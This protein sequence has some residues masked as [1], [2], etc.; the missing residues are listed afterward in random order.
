[1]KS[2]FYALL[3]LCFVQPVFA[4]QHNDYEIPQQRTNAKYFTPVSPMNAIHSNHS[5]SATTRSSDRL[6]A[7]GTYRWIDDTWEGSIATNYTYDT[8][9]NITLILEETFD[10]TSWI[11][12]NQIIYEYNSNNNMTLEISQ[13]WS[14]NDFVN[15]VQQTYEYDAQNRLISSL[16]QTWSGSSWTSWSRILLEYNSSNNIT[17]H[18]QELWNGSAWGNGSRTLYTYDNNQNNTVTEEYNWNGSQWTNSIKSTSEYD[19][20]NKLI[21]QLEEVPNGPNNWQ[22]VYQRI[23]EYDGNNLV[24][25]LGQE[26][27]DFSWKSVSKINN[28]FDADNNRITY[29]GFI[30]DGYNNDWE[31]SILLT[32]QYDANNNIVQQHRQHWNNNWFGDHKYSY[33]F[34]ANNNLIYELKQTYPDNILTNKH[35]KFYAYEQFTNTFSPDQVDFRFSTFP[36]PSK[37]D[38]TIDL[39]ED[40]VGNYQ[41]HIYNSIGQLVHR[42]DVQ[43]GTN[44]SSFHLPNLSEGTYFVQLNVGQK[45]VTQSIFITH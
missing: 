42:K 35:Q 28:T 33:E 24:S 44:T 41:V 4:Q 6:V 7:I 38:F 21:L 37:G 36:N 9:G 26:Y 34:D 29:L 10:G 19:A 13:S 11:N 40:A 1:M 22:Q 20:N 39:G 16:Y 43:N 32:W 18:S 27:L 5:S 30:W 31:N 14:G 12:D 25:I 15:A 8:N 23:Y 3:I 17:K 2:I 45:R